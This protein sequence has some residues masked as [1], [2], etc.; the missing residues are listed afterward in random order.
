MQVVLAGTADG[1]VVVL[2]RDRE[3]TMKRGRSFRLAKVVPCDIPSN[4]AASSD[5]FSTAV[6]YKRS[7]QCKQQAWFLPLTVVQL[8]ACVVGR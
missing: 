7:I 6:Q 5:E 1:A 4:D 2:E 3:G 8:D